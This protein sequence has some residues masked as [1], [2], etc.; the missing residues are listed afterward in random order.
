MHIHD[1]TIRAYRAADKSALSS[2][3]YR[4]SREAHHFL[5][6]ERLSAHRRMIEDIYLDQAENWVACRN[7]IPI[8]FIGLIDRFVGGLFVDPDFQ[9]CGAGRALVAHAVQLKQ[10]LELEVYTANQK[11]CDFYLALGFKEVSRRAVDD[12]GLPFA[13]LTLRFTS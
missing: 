9:G 3:W 13:N 5:G 7:D 4:A 11:A 1:L 12:E 2:I 8:A 6:E 10:D